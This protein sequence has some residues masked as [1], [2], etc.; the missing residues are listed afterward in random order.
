MLMTRT[1]IHDDADMEFVKNFTP[2]DFQAKNFTPSISPNFNTFSD[3]NVKKELNGEIYTTELAKNFQKTINQHRWLKMVQNSPK[4]RGAW[5]S[6]DIPFS[7]VGEF[8]HM[9]SHH[10]VITPFKVHV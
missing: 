7:R 1:M 9:Y 10:L 2:P 5:D 3:K 8:I 4:A 6:K